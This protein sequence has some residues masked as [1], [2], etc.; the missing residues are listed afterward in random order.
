MN[1]IIEKARDAHALAL[2]LT[3]VNQ[4]KQTHIGYC[5][6]EYEWNLKALRED[7]QAADGWLHFYIAKDYTGKIVAAL[8][9]DIEETTAEVWGPFSETDTVE[10][11]EKLW[12][13]F[14]KDYSAIQDYYFLLNEENL[15]QRHFMK[16]IRAEESGRHLQLNIKRADFKNVRDLQSVSFTPEDEAAFTKLHTET[17]PNTY[18]NAKT[19]IS[20]LSNGNILKLLKDDAENLQG[21]AYFELDY[22]LE[23]ASLE[24]L[25]ISPR[26]RGQGIGTVLLREVLTEIFSH[27]MFTEV[28]LTVEAAN[29]AANHLYFQAGFKTGDTLISYRWKQGI[30]NL[31]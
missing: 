4:N 3:E 1:I 2:F 28:Q 17:F 19:I 11:Q 6:R 10:T 5:G 15:Q 13:Q 18:Y 25:S 7:F 16:K 27:P 9:A 29:T 23:E 26:Y 22:E 14:I 12:K 30:H 31:I 8:G 20:R 21:Y 24:Y